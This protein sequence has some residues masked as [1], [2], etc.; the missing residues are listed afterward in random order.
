[1]RPIKTVIEQKFPGMK[2]LRV[3]KTEI[4]GWLLVESDSD[5]VENY[6]YVHESGRYVLSGHSS[7]FKWAEM[8]R[9]EYVRDRQQALLAGMDT[10]KTILLSPM[11]PKLERPVLVFDDPD[12]RFCQQFHPEVQKLVEAGVPV[13]VVL[14]PLVRTHPDTYRKSVAIWCASRSGRGAGAR[15]EVKTGNG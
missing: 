4:P 15:A 8:L 14:Y 6:M 1:M 3:S 11:Q 12:C 7:I 5:Q 2:V 13:A 9:K 10:S